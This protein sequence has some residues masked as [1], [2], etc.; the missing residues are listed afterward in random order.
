MMLIETAV[1]Y[2]RLARLHRRSA[3][4]WTP[5]STLGVALGLYAAMLG[6]LLVASV[7]WALLPGMPNPSAWFDDPLNPL[8]WLMMLGPLAMMLPAVLLGVRWGGRRRGT[9][10]SVAG[11]FR[12]DLMLR[13]AVVVVP[14]YVVV[15][16]G[17]RLISPPEDFAWPPLDARLLIIAAIVLLLGPLQ[18]AAEEY[19][20]RGLPQQ[21]L[22]TWL[23]SPAWGIL[24]PVP[25][26]VL[27]HGY[28]WAG[29]VGIGAFALATGVLVWKTGGLELAILLHTANNMV[30][31]AFAPTSPSSLQQGPI[32]PFWLLI[33]L[34]LVFGV[35]LGL[36]VWVSRRHGLRW[37]EP[38]RSSTAA[39]SSAPDK[40]SLSAGEEGSA[41]AVG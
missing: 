31:F 2:H 23:R 18:C 12:W 40:R 41:V 28:D 33:D 29:Q 13:A 34:P 14:V 6:L 1:P 11:R 36:C 37:N 30:L 35:T 25:L 24:L 26:F 38:L 22:G 16:A 21:L 19:V 17:W 3:R 27:G 5:L 9:I 10:H 4:W 39:P 32:D 20:F 7:V 8:D 15:L